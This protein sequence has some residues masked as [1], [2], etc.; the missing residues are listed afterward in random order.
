MRVSIIVELR[1]ERW[2]EVG[3]PVS[4]GTGGKVVMAM[5]WRPL[6]R[7]VPC[8]SRRQ[9]TVRHRRQHGGESPASCITGNEHGGESPA[10]CGTGGKYGG[11]SPTNCG[12]GGKHAAA[13]VPRQHAHGEGARGATLIEASGDAAIGVT[14]WHWRPSPCCIDDIDDHGLQERNK[15]TR[16]GR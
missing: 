2:R 15:L 12:T 6:P 5:E 16:L 11:E 14:R 10:S 9:G 7:G 13:S 1:H 4:C 8:P 3:C